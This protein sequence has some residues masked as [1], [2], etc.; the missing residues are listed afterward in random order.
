[1]NKYLQRTIETNGFW[2]TD[3]DPEKNTNEELVAKIPDNEW[4]FMLKNTSLSLGRGVF[5]CKTPADMLEIIDMY[6]ADQNLQAE[7]KYKNDAIV[8]HCSEAEKAE[9]TIVPPFVGEHMIDL[10]RGWSE[11]CYEGF[12]TEDGKNVHYGLTEE[13]YFMDH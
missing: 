7:I 13:V 11:Y 3:I 4:P 2:F 12:A 6:R 1:M 10:T 8:C 5:R 9:L